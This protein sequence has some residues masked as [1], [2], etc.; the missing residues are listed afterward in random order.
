MVSWL[1]VSYIILCGLWE[2]IRS[3]KLE[4]HEEVHSRVI[5]MYSKHKIVT[6][7]V[8]WTDMLNY[9]SLYHGSHI[10]QKQKHRPQ[11]EL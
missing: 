2:I 4:V 7:R 10:D 11:A 9:N 8:F 6:R 3:F 1:M 5:S